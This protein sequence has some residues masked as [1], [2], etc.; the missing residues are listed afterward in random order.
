[1]FGNL[2]AILCGLAD[3]AMAQR[4]VETLSA[5]QC[6]EPVSDPRRAAPA[7]AR[8]TNCGGPTWRATSRTSRT[9]ITT[10]ACGPSSAA[11]GCWRWRGWACATR[12][13]HALRAP[14]RRSNALDDWRFTEWFHG[15]TLAPMGMAGQSWNAATF[16]LAQRSLDAV[17]ATAA[18]LFGAPSD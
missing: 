11:S 8:A 7:V 2:L 13:G 17:G 18:G 16:L 12:R 10:A 4:I 3:E 6:A 1:M 14:G 5:A 9:S 15:R